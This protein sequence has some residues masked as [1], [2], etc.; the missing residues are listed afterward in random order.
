MKNTKPLS[1]AEFRDLLKDQRSTEAQEQRSEKKKTRE[2]DKASETME[3]P[4]IGYRI[5][6]KLGS[7]GMSVVFKAQ[8][9]A[10]EQTV[11]LKLLYPNADKKLLKQFVHE[12]MMLMRLDHPNIL[13]GFDFGISKGF[14]FLALEF[15]QGESLAPF[16]EKGFIFTAQFTFQVA[17]QI[18]KALAYLETKGIVHRDVKPANILLVADTAKLCDF[19]LAID[20]SKKATKEEND[21]IT[22]GTVEYI[23]PEQARGA[24]NLDNRSDVYSLGIT[25]IHMMTGI[26]PFRGDDPR[27]VMRRQIYEPI[28][29][30][31]LKTISPLAR[32]ILNNMVAKKPE[33][34]LM[35]DKLL[36]LLEQFVQNAT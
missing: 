7:G 27:E 36:P 24:T 10:T 20:T 6:D 18:A 19:G 3:Q 4:I 12:G 25:C 16:L 32:Y 35:A 31:S 29:W 1:L 30:D 21:A 2:E 23:S 26:L 22:C 14:Y 17:L 28:D 8:N 15:V 33:E 5:V 9:V 11:A 34:R 13:K